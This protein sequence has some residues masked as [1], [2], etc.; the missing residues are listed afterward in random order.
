MTRFDTVVLGG[1]LSGLSFAYHFDKN[2]PVFEKESE[3][4]GLVRTQD[5]NGFRFD[6]APHL[7]HIRSE[8]VRELVFD[9]LGLK[10]KKHQR[11]ARIYHRG[12]VIPY[13]FELNLHGVL[14][15]V[16]DDCLRGLDGIDAAT[17][18]DV[19]ALQSGS[20]KDYVLRAFG[21]GI[22]E[23]YLLPYNRKIWATDPSDMTCEWMKWL[24]TADIEK[25]IRNAVEPENEAFGYNAHFFYPENKGIQE[26]PE[27]FAARLDNVQCNREAATIST[28]T[29][30]ITF[31]DGETLGYDRLVSTLPLTALAECSDLDDVKEA[32]AGLTHTATYVINL[33]VRGHVPADAHWM[34]FP[35]PAL[36]FYRMSFP[37]NFFDRA[38][39]GDEHILAAEVGSRDANLPLDELRSK[40]EQQ[41]LGLDIFDIHEHLFTHCGTIPIAY[42]IYDFERTP[43]VAR[44]LEGF[45]AHGIY[46]IGR[47]GQW[48]YSAMEDAILCGKTLAGEFRNSQ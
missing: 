38:T 48:E 29:K 5:V 7:L 24:P 15:E 43:R 34:Y 16:R 37:K 11:L 27:A 45:R 14:P 33:V 2:V 40:V 9:V 47:Y 21:K 8:Y 17:R 26:L 18:E 10:A 20:Y 35:D 44:L 36:A 32:A 41:V 12:R 1:G 23:H 22:A 4:G 30:T 6:Y 19:Q 28:R 42:S 39:P 13:P 3:P 46:S 25:I 31:A